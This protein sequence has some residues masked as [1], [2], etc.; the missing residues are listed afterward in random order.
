MSCP[1]CKTEHPA[2]IKSH[3]MLTSGR[4][5]L[6]ATCKACGVA[7][8]EPP[9]TEAEYVQYNEW[10][11]DAN[12]FYCSARE[13]M[14]RST[15]QWATLKQIIREGDRVF[16]IGTGDGSVVKLCRDAGFHAEGNEPTVGARAAAK[17]RHGL[18]ILVGLPEAKFNI[19]CLHSVLEHVYDGEQLIRDALN[20]LADGGNLIVKMPAFDFQKEGWWGYEAEH[21]CLYTRRAVGNLLTKFGFRETRYWTEGER[22]IY[23]FKEGLR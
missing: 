3:A 16:D 11:W 6:Y 23:V 1:F 14:R 15:G 7:C 13:S 5:L 17:A 9:L 4:V 2:T 8:H 20:V 21:P 12:G 18:D 10:G 22:A 19:V